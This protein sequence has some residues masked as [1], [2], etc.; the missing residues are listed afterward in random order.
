MYMEDYINIINAPKL[1]EE[2]K[3]RLGRYINKLRDLSKGKPLLVVDS[4][5]LRATGKYAFKEIH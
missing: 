3:Q 5:S 2:G 1:D 4:K